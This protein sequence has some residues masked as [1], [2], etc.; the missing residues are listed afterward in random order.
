MP[1]RLLA[2]FIGL[3]TCIN[4]LAQENEDIVWFESFFLPATELSTQE[5]INN[6][7]DRLLT[8]TET[9]DLPEEIKI[10]K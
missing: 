8:A 2:L 1:M 7:N 3:L 6:R 5:A 4:L 10:K 9:K